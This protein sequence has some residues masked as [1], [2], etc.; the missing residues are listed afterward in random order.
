M[1][2]QKVVMNGV[3]SSWKPITSS[4]PWGAAVGHV[5]FSIFINDLD[6]GIEY[7]LSKFATS[8]WE[9]E[10]LCLGEGWPCRQMWTGMK[11]GLRPMEWI[12]TRLCT[13]PALWPQQPKFCGRVARTLV[14]E[15][16]L[17]VFVNVWL[18]LSQGHQGIY[19][20]GPVSHRCKL[21]DWWHED[22]RL[23]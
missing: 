2:P 21:T 7:I 12:S 23:L 3:K 6:E 22:W 15:T 1:W 8:R 13:G 19:N 14:E 16:D 18:N 4:V 17:E 5:L 9:E 20:T 11:A 10:V